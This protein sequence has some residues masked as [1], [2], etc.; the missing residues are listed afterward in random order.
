LAS[1]TRPS[2]TLEPTC[3]APRTMIFKMAAATKA[4]F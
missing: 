2:A 1:E 3:P 4:R